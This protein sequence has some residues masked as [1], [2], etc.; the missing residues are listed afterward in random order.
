[1]MNKPIPI[2]DKLLHFFLVQ[3]TIAAAN[4]FLLQSAK[5]SGADLD[6][7]SQRPFVESLNAGMALQHNDEREHGLRLLAHQQTASDLR[8]KSHGSSA[9]AV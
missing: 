7:L 4:E 1:M 8:C 5:E 9:N 3:E 2:D 6:N